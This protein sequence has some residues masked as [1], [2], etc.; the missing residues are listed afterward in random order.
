MVP[1]T[2]EKKCLT[3]EQIESFIASIP[4]PNPPEW[5]DVPIDYSSEEDRRFLEELVIREAEKTK[6]CPPLPPRDKHIAVYDL[7]GNV[8]FL[9]IGNPA[10]ELTEIDKARITADIERRIQHSGTS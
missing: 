2:T 6:F 10:V 9:K 3:K 4:A 1:K 8:Q 5:L 7:R